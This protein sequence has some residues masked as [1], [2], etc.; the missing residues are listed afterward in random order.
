MDPTTFSSREL[1]TTSAVAD[2]IT[3]PTAHEK[4]KVAFTVFMAIPFSKFK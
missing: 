4:K 3:A 2:A 1:D